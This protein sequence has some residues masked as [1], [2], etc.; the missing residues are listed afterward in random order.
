[1]AKLAQEGY[2][3]P[4]IFNPVAWGRNIGTEKTFLNTEFKMFHPYVHYG[5][6]EVYRNEEALSLATWISGLCSIVLTLLFLVDE[7]STY[8]SILLLTAVPMGMNL[9]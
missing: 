5:T 2:I 3:P 4:G 1:M 6:A 9:S 8:H 7:Y